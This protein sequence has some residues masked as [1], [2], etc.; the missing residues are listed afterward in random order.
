MGK[1]AVLKRDRGEGGQ[2]AVA[3]VTAGLSVIA[4][5]MTLNGDCETSGRLRIE[6][7]VTGNVRAGALELAAGGAVDGDVTSTEGTDQGGI[8]VE[9]TVGGAVRGQRVEVRTGGAVR[10]GM[11]ARDARVDGHVTGGIT[12]RNRLSLGPRA[13]VE[14][15]IRTTRL[16]MAEGSQVNGTVRTG[17]RAHAPAATTEEDNAE[18]EEPVAKLAAG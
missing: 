1:T 5:E 15:E 3:P 17:D 12:A 7:H 9:G 8:L 14:G 16:V 2:R 11:T 18:A 10:G 13:T 4:R 6:G